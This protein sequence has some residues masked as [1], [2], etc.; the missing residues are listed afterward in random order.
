MESCWL[1]WFWFRFWKSWA[2]WAAALWVRQGSW[3]LRTGSCMPWGTPPALWTACHSLLV[4]YWNNWEYWWVWTVSEPCSVFRF[5]HLQEGCRVSVCTGS[6]CEV[7]TSRSLQ[8]P[9][10]RQKTGSALSE[11]FSADP[12]QVQ[13]TVGF[14][15]DIQVLKHYGVKF[16]SVLSNQ[17]KA[18]CNYF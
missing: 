2:Q 11:Y 5:H 17:T 12:D 18:N 16:V 10:E 6:G 1:N 9:A 15:A 14:T 3:F 4:L 13:V 7:W 8:R